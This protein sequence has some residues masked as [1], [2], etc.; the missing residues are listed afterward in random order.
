VLTSASGALPALS[1]SHPGNIA[2]ATIEAAY[3]LQD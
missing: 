3:V 2:A 1:G